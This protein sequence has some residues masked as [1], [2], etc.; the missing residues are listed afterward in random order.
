MVLALQE[1]PPMTLR[2]N[3]QRLARDAYRSRL[4]A[5]EA[6]TVSGVDS[7]LVLRQPVA[8]T[9]LP[10]FAQGE[11]SVQD[12]G[13]QLAATLLQPQAGERILDACAAPGGKSCHLLELAPE[14]RLTAI[15]IDTQR[16]RRVRDNLARLSLQAEVCQGDAAAPAGAWA[17]RK[18][19]RILLDVPCSATGV[20]RRHPDIK[21]LRKASDIAPLVDTQQKILHAIW[22]LLAPGG[23]LLYATCSLLPEENQL[24]MQRFLEAQPEARERVIQ[25]DWGR[26]CAV[27][28]QTL[29]GEDTMD[30]FYY[31]CLEKRCL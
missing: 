26:A 30:G 16:L 13:A 17:E 9:A 1:R 15:D 20:I 6:E 5:Q 27:G 12:A 21:L 14:A 18:Y 19:Q 28:R 23:L 31:A 4:Q 3:R 25:E 8:V 11:V 29:P 24:Q 22:P 7:A 2:V 10:G